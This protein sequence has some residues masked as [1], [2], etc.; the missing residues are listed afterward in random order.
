MRT[1]FLFQ[2]D[3]LP[4]VAP[5]YLINQLPKELPENP[6]QW[7]EILQD[8]NKLIVPG[9]THWQSPNFH[10]FYPTGS[11]YPSIVGDMLAT[12]FGVIG[13]NWVS[14]TNFKN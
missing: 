6:Q 1:Y 3:V 14:R 4:S 10:A 11:S 12:G 2:S 13:F 8:V 5:G 9:V 7:Q